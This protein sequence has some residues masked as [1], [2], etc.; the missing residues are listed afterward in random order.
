MLNKKNNFNRITSIDALRGV[1]LLGI[2]LVHIGGYFGFSTVICEE[3]GYNATF[4]ERIIGLLLSN[5]CAPIFSMLFGVS[6]YLILRKG[7]YSGRK[8]FWRCFLLCLIGLFNKVFYT[9]DA[10]LL[11]GI[12]GMILLLFRNM[13]VKSLFVVFLVLYISSLVL[14]SF[15]LGDML[16]GDKEIFDRY[17]LTATLS[18]ITSYPLWKSVLRYFYATLQGGVFGTMAY[19]VLGYFFAKQG[20]VENLNKY[21]TKR[22]IALFISVVVVFY[23][24]YVFFEYQFDAKIHMLKKI[25]NLFSALLYATFFLYLY[26][27]IPSA[28]SVF[29]AYGKL[30]LTNYTTQSIYGVI[31]MTMW[32]IPHDFTFGMILLCSL[33]FYALQCLFSYYW[34]KY[35]KYGPLEYLWRSLTNMRFQSPLI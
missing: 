24:A 1:V 4:I 25:G 10:L 15:D 20:V 14:S 29:E 19:F 26:Y 16:L 17:Q 21:V 6:F 5:R 18:D 33:T 31:A 7:N 11:Y 12:C 13:K 22:N 23:A 27:K 9:Y 3:A 2:F 35:F 34:L 30:G 28:F 32:Y 8:F